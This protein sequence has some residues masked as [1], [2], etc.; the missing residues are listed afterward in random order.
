MAF[1]LNIDTSTQQASVSLSENGNCIRLLAS[2]EQKEHA[3]FIQPAIDKILKEQ[4]IPP[5]DLAAI[6]VTE[7]PGSY[8]GLRV[9]MATAKGLCY[10]LNIPLITIGTLEV[11]TVAAIHSL[12]L[13]GIPVNEADL[14]CP[15]IDA[16]R[17]E[18]FTALLNS[19]LGYV[20]EPSALILS[21]GTLIGQLNACKIFIYGSGSIKFQP[22]CRHK[23]ARFISVGFDASDMV[24]LSNQRFSQNI[25]ANLAYTEPF[26]GKEFYS[27]PRL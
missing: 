25:F 19:K 6:A 26:Y 24:S 14:F 17:Q 18:V 11:M 4:N 5:K 10:A 23:N 15:M 20:H 16:R 22:I 3:S 7:G 12:N 13:S 9:G 1:I 27:P 8:T 21:A 2:K